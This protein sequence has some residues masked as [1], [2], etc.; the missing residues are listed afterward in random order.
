[1]EVDE[2]RLAKATESAFR[3]LAGKGRIPGFRPGK[4]PRPV[5]ER[6]L[7]E[8]AVLH[9][10]IDQLL[11]Q[12]Y[13]EALEQEAIEPVDRADYELVT[14][15]PLVVKFTVPVRPTLHLGENAALRV[16]RDPVVLE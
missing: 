3:R 8:H 11:P 7:G 4:A 16:P 14:E 9:E 12:V 13:R 2:E 5:L 1:M 10:A 15:Q 6:H